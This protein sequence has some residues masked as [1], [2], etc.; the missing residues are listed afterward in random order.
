MS[1]Q[2]QID[3]VVNEI[4]VA[5]RELDALLGVDEKSDH[6]WGRVEVLKNE[7]ADME[8]EVDRAR[9]WLSTCGVTI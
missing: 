8:R 1:L 7:I 4:V 9:R 5:R 2:R 6:E 3:D